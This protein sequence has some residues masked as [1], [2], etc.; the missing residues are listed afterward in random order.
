MASQLANLTSMLT[1]VLGSVVA[2][3]IAVEFLLQISAQLELWLALGIVILIYILGI[4]Q[5]LN[6]K[7]QQMEGKSDEP[8]EDQL[9]AVKILSFLNITTIIVLINLAMRALR[10][11]AAVTE[12][13]WDDYVITAILVLFIVFILFQ[14]LVT[15]F[16][17]QKK[18][19]AS[20]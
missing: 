13:E 3:L 20:F 8:S 6:K 19:V 7:M 11:Q 15:L 1:T 17:P 14:K 9:V 12:M 18:G 2:S 16:L 4:Q 10:E 5:A